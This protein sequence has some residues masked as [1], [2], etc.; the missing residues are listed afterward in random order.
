MV[1]NEIENSKKLTVDT[2]NQKLVVFKFR[3]YYLLRL[4]YIRISVDRKRIEK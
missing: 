2:N 1:M 3:E 4:K